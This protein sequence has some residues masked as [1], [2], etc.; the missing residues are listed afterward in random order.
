MPAGNNAKGAFIPTPAACDGVLVVSGGFRRYE[1]YGLDAETGEML[2]AVKLSDIGPSG[3][4][5][6]F[7]VV[8]FNT[9]SC[10]TFA[11]RAKTGE[12]LWSHYLGDPQMSAPSM[13]N[14]RVFA[15]YPIKHIAPGASRDASHALAA[16]AATSGT[17]LW[18]TVIDGDVMTAPV[19]VNDQQVVVTTLAGTLYLLDQ[20]DGTIRAAA[21]A[22]GTSAPV[23]VDGQLYYS[24]RTDVLYD[25]R[26]REDLAVADALLQRRLSLG[27]ADPAGRA[28]LRQHVC[29]RNL[30]DRSAER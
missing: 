9:E 30:G 26:M 23:F 24:R 17:L 21:R 18:Q 19:I 2:W 6:E 3:P 15:A 25:L 13:H 20:E 28:H 16:F 1:Y 22:R 27:D 11:W 5:C 8:V 10:T 29:R 4:V 14:G 12:M 7:G